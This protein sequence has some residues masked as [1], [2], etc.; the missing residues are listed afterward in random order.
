MIRSLVICTPAL[1]DA[2]CG[3]YARALSATR[4][5]LATDY[6]VET[7]VATAHSSLLDQNRNCLASNF[8]QSTA[9]ACLWVDADQGWRT[10]DIV[11]LLEG[12]NAGLGL[13]GLPVSLK[14]PPDFEAARAV[15]LAGG[16]AEDMRAAAYP[17]F[18]VNWLP[19]DIRDGRYIGPT[20]R[21]AGGRY[22]R[23]RRIG[24]GVL[25][26][27]RACVE[28]LVAAAPTYRSLVGAERDPL[29]FHARVS[30]DQFMPEDFD[31]CDCW[32]E[33]GGDAWVYA[34]AQQVEHVG[35]ATWVG[36]FGWHFDRLGEAAPAAG[37][38]P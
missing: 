34:D 26:M 22:A 14:V 2:A 32:R 5:S 29:M 4:M 16:L 28:Q 17:K 3:V 1:G 37:G 13:V 27:T 9:D 31:L 18:N 30:G 12:A 20:R 6:G 35:P 23:V 24:T 11:A 15:A 19:E 25:L 10:D 7:S 38:G 21:I 8:L 33:L 36:D